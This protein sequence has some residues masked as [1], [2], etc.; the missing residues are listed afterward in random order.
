MLGAAD[1]ISDA[2]FAPYGVDTESI[3]ALRQRFAE[4]QKELRQG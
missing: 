3:R 4:W 2:A 1:Q